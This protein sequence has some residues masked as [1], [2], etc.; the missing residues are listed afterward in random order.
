MEE[1]GMVPTMTPNQN[2]KDIPGNPS[3]ATSSH[4]MLNNRLNGKPLR[5]LSEEDWF[6]GLYNGYVVVKNAV[7]PE[8]AIF[9]GSLKK[10]T[11]TIP[12]HG[13][14]PHVQR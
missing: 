6:F 7:S 12:K 10:K 1:R 13:T 14:R 9:C 3:T 5:V 4:L 2:H 8:Q 11:P